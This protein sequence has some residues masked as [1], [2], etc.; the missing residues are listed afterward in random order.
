MMM[1]DMMAGSIFHGEDKRRKKKTA[2]K[3]VRLPQDLLDVL[4]RDAD[5]KGIAFNSLFSSIATKYVEWDRYTSRFGF[6]TCTNAF[7]GMLLESVDTERLKKV[8]SE[9]E[10]QI[11]YDM[12]LFWFKNVSK[13]S[14]VNTLHLIGKYTGLFETEIR[15][16]DSAYAIAVRSRFLA[17]S[18]VLGSYFDRVIRTQLNAIPDVKSTESSIMIK[19]PK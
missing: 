17:L 19:L 2:L 12:M 10:N 1:E 4:E 16:D 9:R 7:F 14:F 13:D 15:E 11:L 8:I 6:V 18:Q 5:D 3:S